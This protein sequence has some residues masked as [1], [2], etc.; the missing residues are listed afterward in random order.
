VS[1]KRS[2]FSP[3]PVNTFVANPKERPSHKH[4]HSPVYLNMSGFR[5]L[6]STFGQ[7]DSPAST[8]FK[9]TGGSASGGSSGGRGYGSGS[10]GGNGWDNTQNRRRRTAGSVSL[11][12]CTPCRQARQ[13]V[14]IY[15]ISTL[16]RSFF[17][18]CQVSGRMLTSCLGSYL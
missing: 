7:D 4:N 12:A 10:G 11:M 17:S 14:S 3:R 13:R 5:S 1:G 2:L 16:P 15:M 9:F 18:T 8:P 6:A